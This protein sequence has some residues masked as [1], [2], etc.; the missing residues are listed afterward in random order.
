MQKPRNFAGGKSIVCLQ[1]IACW[2][3]ATN[4][5]LNQCW[6]RSMS[7][8]G[9]TRSQWV[10]I[11]ID[12]VYIGLCKY[13]SFLYKHDKCKLC[14]LAVFHIFYLYII[15]LCVKLTTFGRLLLLVILHIPRVVNY[16]S[17]YPF[18]VAIAVS[19]IVLQNQ[20]WRHNYTVKQGSGWDV[21]SVSRTHFSSSFIG[22]YFL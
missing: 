2:R 22:Y 20:V 14:W 12:L 3:Q 15:D 17:H 7:P 1:V 13:T 16:I 18:H 6:S 8:Y 5:Y 11:V 10:R 4:H 9:V 21:E 19:H